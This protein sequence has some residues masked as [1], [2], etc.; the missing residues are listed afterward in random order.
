MPRLQKLQVLQ[1]LCER[2][3]YLRSLQKQ[4]VNYGEKIRLL[5]VVE[6]G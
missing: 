5:L 6:A 4:G 1:A 3:R 2:S